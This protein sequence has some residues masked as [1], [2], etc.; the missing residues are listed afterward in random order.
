MDP[1]NRFNLPSF[2]HRILTKSYQAAAARFIR[3]GL[4]E[5]DMATAIRLTELAWPELRMDEGDKSDAIRDYF[6]EKEEMK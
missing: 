6:R 5:E 3:R 2:L 4:S 1:S